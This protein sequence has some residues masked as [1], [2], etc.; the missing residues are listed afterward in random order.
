VGKDVIAKTALTS[1]GSIKTN[2]CK[3]FKML[4]YETQMHSS[5]KQ[6][7]LRSLGE[8]WRKQVVHRSEDATAERQNA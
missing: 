2:E 6:T 1:Q 3:R 5:R 4:N 7:N 8:A